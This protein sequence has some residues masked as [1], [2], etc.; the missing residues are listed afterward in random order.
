ML[1]KKYVV[2]LESLARWA[3][4]YP[5]MTIVDFINLILK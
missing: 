1:T 4:L 5:S 3:A 2:S